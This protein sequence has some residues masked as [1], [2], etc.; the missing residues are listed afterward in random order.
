MKVFL[1]PIKQ[2]DSKEVVVK[3]GFDMQLTESSL[4]SDLYNM[5]QERCSEE[6]LERRIEKGDQSA[7]ISARFAEEE[8]MKV[9]TLTGHPAFIRDTLESFYN[10]VRKGDDG[11][12]FVDGLYAQLNQDL[13]NRVVTWEKDNAKDAM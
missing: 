10:D 9:V 11:R 2:E 4:E 12:A 7:A 1:A 8:T 13:S 3:L 5:L 6:G